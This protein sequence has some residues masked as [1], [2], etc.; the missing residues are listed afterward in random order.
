[1][2]MSQ[3]VLESFTAV[4]SPEIKKRKK[5]ASN[6]LARSVYLQSPWWL[7]ISNHRSQNP[8]S[9]RVCYWA[10]NLAYAGDYRVSETPVR[11]MRV[12]V[13]AP[14]FVFANDARRGSGGWSRETDS[15]QD[16]VLG[17]RYV[18]RGYLVPRLSFRRY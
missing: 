6:G 3:Q 9:R 5:I 13:I 7:T 2:L 4:P 15:D 1:M 14:F 16:P 17:P 8:G 12:I 10:C 18:V 11:A